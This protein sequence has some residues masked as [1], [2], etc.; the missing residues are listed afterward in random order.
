MVDIKKIEM[1]GPMIDEQDKK[2]VLDALENGWYGEKK[3]F[4]CEL[5][6]K[7]FAKYHNRKFALMTT[8]CTSSIHLILMALGLKE[9]DEVI[10]PNC[11]WIASVAPI[12]YTGAKMVF[13]D[14]NNDDWCINV[15]EVEKKISKR[16]KAIISVNLYGNMANWNYL[17]KIEQKYGIPV[18]EDAAESLGSIY[19]NRKSGSF[20]IASVFS[21]HR[22]KTLT[23]GEGGM[24]LLDDKNLFERC[25]FLRDHG[26]VEG[27]VYFNTEVAYKYMP[28]NLQAALGYSQFKKLEK[29]VKKKIE[30]FDLYKKNLAELDDIY[31]NPLIK[32]GR[33]SVWCSTIIIGQSYRKDKNLILDL[34]KKEG[35]TLRPFFYPLTSLP[36]F[37]EY[38]FYSNNTPVAFDLSSRGINL[39]SALN[40]NTDEINSICKILKKILLEK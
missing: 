17:E 32:N 8:N 7:E 22:T 6:E 16:T 38:S 18:I 5:F 37:T 34:A 15:K 4:Y 13:V 39:P 27:K 31:F 19:E 2:F 1:S 3:Y 20:G 33:N 9:G 25:K 23:T 36:A 40:L 12:K 21:F 29:L 14:I 24:L 30:I 10:V 26:R 35:L 28:F 11:T